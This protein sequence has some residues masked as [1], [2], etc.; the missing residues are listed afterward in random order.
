MAELSPEGI[1]QEVIF[2]LGKLI[3][4]SRTM[5]HV[6]LTGTGLNENVIREMGTFLKRSRALQ[7]LH[8]SGNPGLSKANL[9]YLPGRIIARPREDIQRFTRIQAFVKNVF[10]AAGAGPSLMNGIKVKVERDT[11]FDMVHRADPIEFDT[12]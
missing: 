4:H 8:L 3:K 6:N 9:D 1:E 5:Q 12:S 10:S 11:D 2:K 7:V